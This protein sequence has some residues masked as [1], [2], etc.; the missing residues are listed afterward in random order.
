MTGR[1]L[2]IVIST[3]IATV[4]AVVV[5]SVLLGGGSAHALP[6]VLY[7]ATDGICGGASPCHST[8]QDAVDAAHPGDEIRVAQGD[9]PIQIGSD[10]VVY[11]D[12]SLTIRGGYTTSDWDTPNPEANPTELNALAQGRVMMISGTVGVTI[13]GLRLTYG[14]AASLGGHSCYGDKDAGGGIYIDGASVVISHTMVMTSSASNGHG[15][16]I[17]VKESPSLTIKNATIQGNS[18]GEGGGLYLKNAQVSVGESDILDNDAA[19]YW[20][21]CT[22]GGAG[23]FIS[24]GVVEVY[25]ATVRDNECDPTLHGGGFRV[26]DGTVTVRDSTIADNRG[27]VGGGF[28]ISSYATV[29]VR[30]LDNTITS[31]SSGYGGAGLYG[32]LYS[33]SLYVADN[34]VLGNTAASY[35]QGGGLHVDGPAEI[36]NNTIQ[37]NSASNTAAN[38]GGA[39]LNRGPILFQ[40]NTVV[41]NS[42]RDNAVGGQGGGL[43]IAGDNITVT[44]NVIQ[45]NV[46]QAGFGSDGDGGGIYVAADAILINNIVTDNQVGGSSGHGSGIYVEGAAPTFYHTTVANNTGGDGSGVYIDNDSNPGQAT[47]YNTIVADQ[48]VGVMVSGGSPQNL[49]TLYGVLWSGNSS[50]TSGTMFAFY[51]VDGA[52]AFKDP[53][54]LD[55]H[56]GDGSK[57]IDAVVS[58]ANVPTDIDGQTRPHYSASDLGADE[59]WPLLAVKTASPD[60]VEPGGVMTYFLTLTNAT[61]APMAVS[62]S[63]ALPPEVSCTGQLTYTNGS[64][65]CVSDVITWNGTVLTTTATLITWPAGVGSDVSAGITITNTAA[66]TDTHGVFQTGPALVVVPYRNVYLPLVLRVYR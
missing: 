62:L 32:S 56:I 64:G 46:A 12:K 34:Q 48:T 44:Q 28:E 7:V 18:A 53:V 40:G 24:G 21:A 13:E 43:Y 59:W 8:V 66:V 57:A 29:D 5:A 30:L 35:G 51:E 60:T 38:G 25:S 15:G 41:G 10:Q 47:L 6:G 45:D 39:F 49:A 16:G 11:V 1:Q 22:T 4:L 58:E 23:F 55:Y 3:L 50:K 52:P 26:D 36:L 2:R 33:G 65:A 37:G 61:A 17:Y 63:D 27:M 42:T 19:G 20:G 14:S 54:G 31:N 9:Y